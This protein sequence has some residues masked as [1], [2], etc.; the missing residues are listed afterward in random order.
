[1]KKTLLIVLLIFSLLFIKVV[2]AAETM[3]FEFAPDISQPLKIISVETPYQLFQPYN[4]FISGVDLW[5]DNEG[6]EGTASFGFRDENDNLL[7]AK[8]IRIPYLPKTWGGKR[9]HIDFDNQI[10][11]RH[12]STYKIKILTS[13]PNFRLYWADRIQLLQH[14]SQYS[15]E[16]IVGPAKLGTVEQD[17]AFKF[18]LY[19]KNETSP[20]VISNVTSTIISSE[21]VKIE[22]N[23]NELVDWKAAFGLLGQDYTQST[24]FTGNYEFCSEGIRTCSSILG[25][26]P[27]STYNYQLTVKDEWG[28]E[29]QAI[30]LFTTPKG[31]TSE[32][33]PLEESQEE[34]ITE[35]FTPLEESSLT[36]VTEV[37]EG[38]M[39]QWET[40]ASG[41]PND[42]YRVDV[43]NQ[44]NILQQQI[45]VPSGVHQTVINNLPSGNYYTIVYSNN[46]GVFEKIAEPITIAVSE[47]LASKSLL[48][49]LKFYR[50]YLGLIFLV[51]IFGF[52]IFKIF[53]HSQQ[54]TGFTL[55]EIVIA[56]ALFSGIVLATGFFLNY[57]S[58][59]GIFFGEGL[60]AQQE[61]QEVFRAMITELRSMAPSNTGSYPIAE[62]A[63][64]SLL[65]Y[66]DIDKD[67]L[68]E[69]IRYFL[70]GTILK[71]GVIKPSGNPFTYN[72][73][74]EEISFSVRN[75]I[76]TSSA[77]FSYYDK[78]YSGSEPAMTPP[79]N[80]SDIRLIKVDIAIN[81]GAQPRQIPM[82][83]SIQVAPRNLKSNP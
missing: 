13:M 28:N 4:D 20:P 78:N 12:A 64:S 48:T 81:Q 54:N 45:F 72:P 23:A 39:I 79:V 30:G 24:N 36:E 9:L 77:I 73:A 59:V 26:S 7:A 57:M 37:S 47:S 6:E 31:L 49:Q 41:E 75:I 69:R 58:N 51:I 27:D 52:L 33:L 19:E 66:G 35:P 56:L 43:F 42:G 55:I 15:L 71:K 8:S 1:M 76:A 14:T 65:F 68:F 29:A 25:V 3:F 40:P 83:F 16:K 44:N 38:G 74:N 34:S 21:Q 70:D 2:F 61:V 17:F 50:I 60:T 18:A 46:N 5:V 63:T 67:N 62:A 32:T 53:K 80:I 22:F 11:V 10:S 82:T